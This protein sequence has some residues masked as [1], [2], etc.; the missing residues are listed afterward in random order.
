MHV[1]PSASH[2]AQFN[3]E[4]LRG[5]GAVQSFY[6]HRALC[7]SICKTDPMIL[8]MCPLYSSVICGVLPDR[9]ACLLA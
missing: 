2:T 3:S 9:Q 1:L 4:E 7:S 8:S 5:S 6:I